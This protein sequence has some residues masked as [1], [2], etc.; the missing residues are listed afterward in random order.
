MRCARC[1]AARW[2]RR[3]SP[4]PGSTVGAGAFQRTPADGIRSFLGTNNHAVMKTIY[5]QFGFDPVADFTPLALV[6]RQPFILVV[7]PDVPAHTCR[8]CLPG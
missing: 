8:N 1:S 6:A 3:T 7:H 2:W 5:P 4:A